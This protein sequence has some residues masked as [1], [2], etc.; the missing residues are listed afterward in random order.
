MPKLLDCLAA[1]M[2]GLGQ[3]LVREAIVI[4]AASTDQSGDLAAD[5]GCQVITLPAEQRG[6]GRQLQAGA[7]AAR[8]DWFL[9]LHADTVLSDTWAAEVAHHIAT[10]PNKAA[11]FTLAFDQTGSGPKRVAALANLR[12]RKLGLP[13]GDQGLL[14]SRALYEEMGGYRDFPLMEDVDLVRR[15]TPARLTGLEAKA[16]TSGSKYTHGGWWGVPLRN[17]I[18]VSAYLC[19]VSP[20]TL[21]QYYK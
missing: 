4:D 9:F 15:L 8:G 7:S 10:N 11:F 19:G 17:L 14:I 5:M 21:A 1:L 12:A 2:D 6:R 3:D 16:I 18:L 20:K 13:Y